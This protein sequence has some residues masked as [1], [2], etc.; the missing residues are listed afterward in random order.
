MTYY[1][2]R[3]VDQDKRLSTTARDR[4]EALA[5]FGKELGLKLTLEDSDAVVAS[6][7]LAEREGVRDWVNH[8]IPVF[9]TPI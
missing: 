8:T 7:L 5:I 1:N 3:I 2:L 6:Y 9:A 4:S